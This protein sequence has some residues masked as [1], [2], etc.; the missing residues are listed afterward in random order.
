MLAVDF[1]RKK[2][3]LLMTTGLLDSVLIQ[4]YM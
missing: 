4:L 2:E 1:H 3:I